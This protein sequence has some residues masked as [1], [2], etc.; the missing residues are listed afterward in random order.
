MSNLFERTRRKE[1]PAGVTPAGRD[2]PLRA[3]FA[4][5][6]LWFLDQL[7]PGGV[8]YNIPLTMRV[9][10]ELDVAHLATAVSTVVERHEALRTAFTEDGG[11]PFQRVVAAEPVPVPVVEVPGAADEQ[12]DNARALAGAEI[13]KPFDLSAAPL[14]RATLLRLA[15]QDHILLLVLHHVATDAWS[16]GVLVRELSAVYGALDAGRTPAL[17][18]LPVQYADYAVWE[19]DRMAGPSLKRQ[20]D[21]WKQ[22]LSG[23]EPALELPTDRPRPSIARQEGEAVAWTLPPELVD[24]ARKLGAEED[25]TLY[26][27]LLAAFQLVLSRYVNNEDVAVGTPVANRGRSEIEGLIGFFV[28]TVVLRTDLSGDPTYRELLHRVRDVT[29]GAFAHG[30]LPFEYLVEHVQPERDLSRNP[31]VQVLFQMLNIPAERLSLGP[32]EVEQF[33][34]GRV[35]TRMD[36]EFH[37][38][39]ADDGGL[40]GHIVFSRALFDRPTVER[41]LHHLD[42]VLRSV[43]ADPDR[44]VS[45]ISL[46]DDAERTLVLETFNDTARPVPEGSLPELFAAQVRRSPD[47]TA[48]EHG[49]DRLT[50]AELDRRS[51]RLAHHLRDRGVGP[52]ALVGLCVARGAEAIV[53]LLGILKTGAAYVPI[54]PHHPRDRIRFTLQDAQVATA[55]TQQDFVELFETA[56]TSLVLVDAERETFAGRPDTAPAVAT[57]P[58]DLA[59]VIYTSGSTGVPKGILMPAACIINLVSWQ[60]RALPIGSDAR[61]SQFASLTFD[62]SLQEIFSSLLYGETVVVPDEELRMDPAAYTR[63]AH[64][65][66]LSQLFVPNVMLRAISEEVD[67]EG[68]E[69][70]ALRHLSQAGEPL[71]LHQDLR[72]LCERRPELRLHNHY[73]PSE[74]HVVTSYS[75]PASV[76]D[77]PLTAP[78]GRP[79]DNTRVYVVDRGLRPVPVGV[80]GELCVAGAGLA[81]GYAGRPEQTAAR[82]VRDPFADDGS[83]MYRSGDLVRWLPDGNLEFLGRIDDQVKI[84]GFRIEPGEIESI[85][86]RH[87]DVLHGAVIVREDVPGDKRLV[88]Y[89]VAEPAAADRDERL[90]ET[91]RRH[92]ESAVPEYMVPSSVVLLESMP[93]TTGGKIDRGALPAPDLRTV[94]EVGYVAPSTPEEEAVCAVYAELL[95]AER[96]GVEDD[97][98]ALGGH[99]LIATRVVAK[100]RT[101]LGVSVPLKAIFQHRTPRELGAAMAAAAGAGTAQER[102][103]LVPVE[104]SRSLPVP[105]SFAQRQADMFF[106]DILKA[107]HWNIPLA[108]RVT[109]EL[110]LVQLRRAMEILVERHEAL[111]ITVV[112]EPG[113]YA[114]AV[115]PSAPL[116]MEV[117]DVDD[118]AQAPVLAGLEVAK[119]F[120]LTRDALARVSVLRLG[121]RDHVLVLAL[122]HLVT[123]GWS[124][125]V[126]V[127]D[128]SA[129]YSALVAGTEADLPDIPV[130]Y[131]DY[132][133]WEQR[134]LQGPALEE[135]L[136]HWER[137]YAGMVPAELPTDR[138]R[139]A[140]ASYDSEVFHWRLEPE[141][142][143]AARGLGESAHA[144]LFMTL[145]TAL[146]LVIS[147]RSASPDVL[148]GMPMAGR[149]RDELEHVVG[150]VSKLL[151]VR[152]DVGGDPAFH[153]LLVKVR[154]AM[155]DAHAHQDVPFVHSVARW[156]KGAPLFENPPVK[157]VFQIVNTP[158]QTLR[159]AEATAEPFKVSHPPVRINLDLEIDLYEDAADGALVGTVLY[160]STLFDRATVES[161]CGDI[162]AVLVRAA[163]DAHRPLSQVWKERSAPGS[164][165]GSA[166]GSLPGARSGGR[167]APQPGQ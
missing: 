16:Q 150:L 26:M 83:R 153:E 57:S 87:E 22:Q 162:E 37:L 107:G 29:L 14:V 124:R 44:P 8:S 20:L 18:A 1:A 2:R 9:R 56:D 111:R 98:F 48:V 79:I 99:S 89:A 135:L 32:L 52:E 90:A 46:L 65:Q 82:F 11:E 160:S 15:E 17:P 156:A 39:K 34:P 5:T 31:L 21:Y 77:W 163:E 68:T 78:I 43:L 19:R 101:A 152:T 69:L 28:N 4:Q 91:L 142:V 54:D 118:P 59:Y 100:L 10:G 73:G 6:R 115:R 74:A 96:V 3:S 113:G 70:S 55:V 104:R 151:A 63:W 132:S 114:Q 66:G 139:R 76:S 88:A 146:K 41:L 24:A 121:E 112:T 154:D 131:T 81:R 122:Q 45:G 33:D 125:G 148:V 67:A 75:L 13:A 141:V 110:D 128:L 147:I 106:E 137:H 143:R 134:W 47:A 109:G 105:L 138:P 133:L 60:K 127:R 12:L 40:L 42:V 97:F 102:P 140:I 126:L 71:S 155:S 53:A 158:P 149:D 25:A 85:L 145:L 123:D 108:M 117:I 35:L 61:T 136:D 119:P 116:R 64:E 36:L 167:T 94:L 92:I 129:V 130:Q 80:P 144:T 23:M 159:L 49:D 164:V 166:P 50:Y 30:E 165:S 161:L 7:E 157:V 86:V 27:T 93:L 84:R 62:I 58:D 51:N 72:E 95:G 103:P 38:M 120:D